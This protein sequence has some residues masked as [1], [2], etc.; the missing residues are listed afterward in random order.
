MDLRRCRQSIETRNSQ[1]G[2]MGV[3]QLQAGTNIG[4]EIKLHASL[5]GAGSNRL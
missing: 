5:T 1:L 2:K 3:E 4:F